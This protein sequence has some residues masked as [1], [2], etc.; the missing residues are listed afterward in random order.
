MKLRL[1]VL[2][3]A[4]ASVALVLTPIAPAASGGRSGTPAVT[5]QVTGSA[6]DLVGSTFTGVFTLTGVAL[7]NG[8][9]VAVG[10]L[11]GTLTDAL[12][13][14]IAT[15]T[16]AVTVPLQA[17][18]SCTVLHLDLGPIDLNVLGLHVTTNEIILDITAESGPGQ[19]I[20]NLVCAVAH[21]LD[22]P[23]TTLNGIANLLNNILGRL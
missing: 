16:Q 10:T 6:T 20:G 7:Q 15:V 18:G 3:L 22:N 14:V 19:L 12:G 9:L 8:Q 17:T 4:L 1:C 23:S 2:A 21:L 13:N 11:T 5:T